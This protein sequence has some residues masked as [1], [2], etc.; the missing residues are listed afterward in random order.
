[1]TNGKKCAVF[2]LLGQSNAVGH[3]IPMDEAER[4]VTPMKNVFGLARAENQSFDIDRL[5]FSGY[6]SHSMNLAETQDHTH[7]VANG[8]AARWQA[9][10]DAGNAYG[11][12]DLYIIHI[13]IGAQGVTEGYLWHPET[14]KI[15]IPGVLGKVK[16]SLFSFTSH[17]FSLLDAY[18]AEAG[19]EYEVIGL[20]WRGGEN[21]I[22]APRETLAEDLQAIY[23]VL[24]ERFHTLLHTPPVILHRLVCIDRMHDLD[25]T[26]ELEYFEKMQIINAEFDRLAACY[27]NV[28]VFDPATAPQYRE[29]IRGN[30][31]FIRDNVH[32]TPEVNGWVADKIL[33]DYVKQNK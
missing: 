16:I 2:I 26:G 7:S 22:T 13:A 14:E 17:I 27:E 11:L 19:K 20:H 21:D 32:F 18:F 28:S 8:L 33:S 9:H 5:C 23:T 31:L 6:T 4:I 25:P 24:F 30:G 3:G 29:D 15:L 10:I 12:P 1:M